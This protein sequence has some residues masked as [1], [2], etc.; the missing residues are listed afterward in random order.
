MFLTEILL[1]SYLLTLCQ[2]WVLISENMLLRDEKI[3]LLAVQ[4][5]SV[6]ILVAAGVY[7][8]QT[9]SDFYWGLVDWAVVL[10]V[11]M[12]KLFY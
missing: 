12:V 8:S 9:M 3:R 2:A 5:L 10:S 7:L 1:F 4:R 6:S 11:F